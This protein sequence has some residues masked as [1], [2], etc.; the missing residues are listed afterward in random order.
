MSEFVQGFD[1]DELDEQE[2]QIVLLIACA[3][4]ARDI[5]AE[6]SHLIDPKWC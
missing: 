3:T 2:Q 6:M 1:K 5:L 4:M